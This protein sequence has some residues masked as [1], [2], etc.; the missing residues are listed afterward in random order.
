[1]IKIVKNTFFVLAICLF[2]AGCVLEEINPNLAGVWHC[3]ETSEI[4]LKST[5]GTSIFDVV[6]KQDAE[7]LSKY[8]IENIYDLGSSTEVYATVS[9]SSI[10]IPEQTVNGF[11][12]KGS[13]TINDNYDL[14]YMTYTVDDGGGDVDHLTAEFAR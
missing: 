4:F 14:I 3:T 5:K 8:Y 6:F 1:M 11:V 9:G 7:N 12:I 10:S 2:F 13:G